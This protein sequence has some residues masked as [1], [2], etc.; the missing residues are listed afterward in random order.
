M[1]LTLDATLQAAQDG[2]NH[3][4]IVDMKV[5]K[6]TDDYPLNGDYIPHDNNQ[7]TSYPVLLSDG[8]LA[9]V[10]AGGASAKQLRVVFSDNDQFEFGNYSIVQSNSYSVFKSC[11]AIALDSSDNIG[12]IVTYQNSSDIVVAAI[13]ISAAGAK[14]SL[15]AV[16][17]SDTAYFS[18]GA[19]ALKIADSQ[20]AA[21][22][23]ERPDG[24]NWYIYKAESTDFVS[25]GSPAALSIGGLD[26]TKELRDPKIEK[27]ADGSYIVFFSYANGSE[28]VYNL[29]YST[30]AD[31]SNWADAQP[32]TS[33]ATVAKKY[34]DSDIIQKA[35]GSIMVSF[36]EQ[37]TYL[38]KDKTDSGWLSTKQLTPASQHIDT[39]NGKLYVTCIENYD[40]TGE[41]CSGVAKIDIATWSI[42][43]FY[44]ESTTPAIPAYFVS[45]STTYYKQHGDGDYCVIVRNDGICIV[46]FSS[47][48]IT[49]YY[50]EDMSGTYGAGT[51]QNVNISW[52]TDIYAPATHANISWVQVS[53]SESRV[54]VALTASYLYN[55]EIIIGYIDLT[56]SAPYDFS[57]IV[58][59]V[60][61]DVKISNGRM[62]PD[63]GLA[64]FAYSGDAGYIAA[65]DTNNDVL[66]KLYK[67]STYGDFPYGG[68]HDAVYA[69]GKVWGT[70]RW[71]SNYADDKY[72]KGL[73]EIDLDTDQ[74]IYHDTP[75]QDSSDNI[76]ERIKYCSTTD[77]LIITGD[78]GIKIFNITTNA[79]ECIN[80]D[81]HPEVI[82]GEDHWRVADYDDVNDVILGSPSQNEVYL[83]PRSGAINIVRYAT[84]EYTTAWAFSDV[85]TLIA[86][87]KAT[88]AAITISGDDKLYTTWTD[89]T[90]EQT[91]I[92]LDM[93]GS[94]LDCLA[95]LTDEISVTRSIDGTPSKL[96]FTLT[97]GHL[98][99]QSNASSIINFYL[100]KGNK[101]TLRFGETVSGVDYYANQGSFLISELSTQYQRGTYPLVKVIAYDR[102]CLWESHQ[103]DVSAL[104]ETYPEDSIKSIV[105]AEMGDTADNYN[106]PTFAGRFSFDA[107]WIDTYLKDIVE[108]IA[109]RFGY[110]LTMD[111]NDK[112]TARL[113][114]DSNAVNHAYADTTK[115][116]NFTPDDTFSDWTNRIVVTGESLD[117]TEVLYDEERITGLSGTVGW[118]GF[119]KDKKV[120]YSADKSSRVRFPRLEVLESTSGI[121]FQLAGDVRES[122]SEIDEDDKYCIVEITAPNL[123]PVLIS[124]LA[125]Y[126][127]GNWLGDAVLSWGAGWTKPVGR[128]MEGVGLYLAMMVLGSV[129]NYQFEIY[130]R[131]V[132]YVRRAVSGSADDIDFQRQIG[133]VVSNKIEGFLTDTAVRCADVAEF[134]MMIARCQRNR[135]KLSK[136]THL[137]DQ[138]G[139]TISFPHPYTGNTVTMFVTDLKRRYK[140]T[141]GGYFTDELEGWVV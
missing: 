138:E 109:N 16:R 81:N 14:L 127:A 95:Y 53:A 136:I 55:N 76:L 41:P 140:P 101:V 92:K 129:G 126:A 10:Y 51:E 61:S 17:N 73:A 26:S 56:Q 87:Y 130:G 50:F 62:Y 48:T 13:K 97:H 34:L 45:S 83:V 104:S 128:A 69:G 93:F 60:S 12:A 116:V 66:L 39:V 119:N 29:H 94:D 5:G 38:S 22:Y 80:N 47:D 31:L 33:D 90:N 100:K 3:R 43:K 117:Y 20:Y 36:S 28:G 133:K 141:K 9:I 112:L 120:W 88:Q 46:D 111:V 21:I 8:R 65:Y 135:A 107:Q 58:L 121:L 74:I 137:Q 114:S 40:G 44:N 1:A 99:D 4:P 78:N 25:W 71:T 110:Y 70:V 122:I 52:P 27:L 15:K 85:E 49:P 11:D 23:A 132:G 108:Q 139:D 115:I 35:D 30:S 86:G 64:V 75:W 98:F 124:A 19:S 59:D 125:I 67:R 82:P 103:V 113:I 102:R 57:Q 84:G 37:N 72:K 91:W 96:E 77:E 123:I 89:A 63:D 2:D 118:W 54:Y 105:T 6:S 131:P 7:V 79:W 42:D 24:T 18:S 134:E 32:F 106:L 68:F